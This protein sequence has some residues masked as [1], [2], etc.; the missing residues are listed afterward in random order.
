MMQQNNSAG[1]VMQGIDMSL[2]SEPH[3]FIR[4]CTVHSSC[5]Q[6]TDT[7]TTL[8][9]TCAT[10]GHYLPI[11]TRRCGQQSIRL[12]FLPRD[13]VLARLLAMTQCLSICVC[14]CLSQVSVLSEG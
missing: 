8:R 10:E 3:Q 14:V 9:A 5:A 7:Q 4:L 2:R 12:T 1:R 6:Q 11:A 13:A